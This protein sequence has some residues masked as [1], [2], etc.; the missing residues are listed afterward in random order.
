MSYVAKR[1]ANIRLTIQKRY[2]KV[3][4]LDEFTVSFLKYKAE[5]E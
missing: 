1:I 4:S 3:I 2:R 5:W